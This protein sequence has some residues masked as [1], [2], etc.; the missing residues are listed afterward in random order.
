MLNQPVAIITGASRGIG[1]AIAQKFAKEGMVVALVGR[2]KSALQETADFIK[3]DSDQPALQIQA[4]L[5]NAQQI[6]SIVER[7][8]DEWGQIDVL[9]NNAGIMYMKPFPELGKDEIQ[10][11]LDVNLRAIILLTQRALPH[12]KKQE[13][14]A[15]INIASLA[16]KNPVKNGIVYAATKWALRGFA[17]SLMLEVREDNIRVVTIF[18]GSVA[19]NL[20]LRSASAPR[21]ET[22]LQPEDVAHAAYSAL[23][24]DRRA[25]MSEIDLRPTNPKR[26]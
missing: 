23:V 11:M 1:R 6:E 3:D 9:V 25:M 10:E 24:V 2:D 16:G 21:R 19:T 15:I 5:R 22:M 7:T 17:A 8:I 12:I 18:P 14:G 4:D 13:N 20:N 26:D